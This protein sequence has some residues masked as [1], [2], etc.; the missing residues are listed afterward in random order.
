M[1][2]QMGIY[3]RFLSAARLF[4]A[5]MYVWDNAIGPATVG[6]NSPTRGRKW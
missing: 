6:W 2:F 4:N 1:T 3:L 5:Y